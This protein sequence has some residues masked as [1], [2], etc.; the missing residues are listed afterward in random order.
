MPYPR[1]THCPQGHEYTEENTARWGRGARY[2]RA[3]QR[4]KEV[5]R[6]KERRARVRALWQAVDEAAAAKGTNRRRWV[7]ATLASVLGMD[8]PWPSM[9]P[10]GKPRGASMKRRA[11]RT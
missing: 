8:D 7:M 3:C 11:A 9:R 10:N 6:G 5:R 2:C 1:Q 4:T